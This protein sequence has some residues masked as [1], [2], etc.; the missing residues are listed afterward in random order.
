[1]IDLVDAGVHLIRPTLD[2]LPGWPLPD[3][4]SVR[5]YQEGDITTW[6]NLH[7]D[8]EPFFRVSAGHFL[9]SFGD[10]LDALPDRM[11]FVQS[12]Q[13]ED[14]GTVTAWWQDDWAGRGQWGQIHWVV[15]ARAHQRRG[16]AKPMTALALHRLAREQHRAMLGTNAQRLWAIKSYLDC[17]FLPDPVER[18]QAPVVQ[19]WQALQ[20]HL[21]HP[22]IAHWLSN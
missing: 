19:G 11:F 18:T 22:A 9:E 5:A 15:V 1:M 12:E 16:L 7:L 10:H 21:H 17:G 4:Y 14:V 2:D 6:V 8:A 3:G 20:Q 13:G